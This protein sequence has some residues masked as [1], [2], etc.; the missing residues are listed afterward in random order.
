MNKVNN[1]V[2]SEVKK[3]KQKKN[4]I[5]GKLLKNMNNLEMIMKINILKNCKQ[6][7]TT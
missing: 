4:K 1:D 6:A 5:K 7:K 2:K 3:K